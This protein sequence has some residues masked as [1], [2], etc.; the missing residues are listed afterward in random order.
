[1]L[2]KTIA[3]G[4]S[5]LKSNLEIT[6]LQKTTA[7]NRQNNVRDAVADGFDIHESFLAGS[8]ARSTMI[9]P[10]KES[11]VD[12]FVLLEAKYYRQYTPATLLDK[13]RAILKR[14]YPS[15]PKIS[16]NSQAV[17]ITFTDFK[18]DVV[19]SFYRTDGG[20]LIPDSIDGE[21]ISADPTVHH[22]NLTDANRRHGG[23]LIPVIKMIKS[24]NRCINEAFHGFYLE[25]LTKQVLT[26]VT[27]T[28]YPSAVRYVFDK[29]R[30]A[31]KYTIS[32]PAGF[33]DQVGGLKG[34]SNI[35]DAV[36][37]FETAYSR[38]VKAESYADSGNIE[39]AYG[40]WRKIFP[41]YF[42]TYR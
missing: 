15:T 34:V 24:W 5:T 40:E 7:A 26:N 11:D 31:V 33:G 37:R 3:S 20:Y 18:V 41:N 14:T 39:L 35:K 9:S 25:L 42:P 30:E 2:P 21:W 16:R 17:T 10:L 19:P 1:M 12:I 27:I 23:E 8:Y 36:S 29:G 13:L 4:F 22:G 28:D 6:G 32:D 38:A